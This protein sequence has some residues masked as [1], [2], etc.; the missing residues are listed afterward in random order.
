MI[1]IIDYGMGNLHSIHKALEYVGGDAVITE[2]PDDLSKAERVVLPGIGAF[3]DGIANLRKAG[4]VEALRREVLER[5]KPFLGICLGMQLLATRSFEF[6][7]HEGLGFIPG[8]VKKFEFPEAKRLPI[9][10]VGWNSVA[11][12]KEHELLKGIKNNSDFYFVHSFRYLPADQN[13]VIA[14]C[15]YGYDF[16][17]I[18]GSANIFATQFHP[19]KSQKDGL[20]LLIN[21]LNW[22]PQ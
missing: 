13:S 15:D 8:E 7:E 1:A 10:H 21:F 4:F 17:A 9:P 5:K 11:I 16:P 3:G 18:V 12:R 22:T 2:N 14:S 20:K 19:E 6:G